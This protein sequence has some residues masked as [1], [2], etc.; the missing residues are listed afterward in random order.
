MF[1]WSPVS[2]RLRFAPLL[3]LCTY[4]P[5]PGQFLA[6]RNGSERHL[7]DAGIVPNRGKS[8]G[9]SSGNYDGVESDEVPPANTRSRP[10]VFGAEIGLDI[11]SAQLYPFC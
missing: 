10:F 2:P 5:G 7:S 1:A 4:L 11:H 6:R 8:S 3:F 9:T